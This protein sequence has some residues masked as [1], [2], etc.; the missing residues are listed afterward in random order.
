ML[1]LRGLALC[2]AVASWLALGGCLAFRQNLVDASPTPAS[3]QDAPTLAVLVSVQREVNGG[4]G[5]LPALYVERWKQAV[6]AGYQESGLFA[7]VRR[8]LGNADLQARVT[9]VDRT[10]A[11]RGV[12]YLSGSTFLLVPLRALDDFTMTT[13]LSK[14]DAGV[15][16]TFEKRE[17][18][19]TYYQLFLAPLTLF[20]SRDDV[21][22]DAVRELALATAQ[23]AQGEGLL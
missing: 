14:P 7:D 9:I 11:S 4:S 5:V 16:G 8:G 23:E 6:V 12:T 3:P 19:T 1:T 22:D 10:S 15:I 2:L 21:F 20:A 13:T 17:R 18:V